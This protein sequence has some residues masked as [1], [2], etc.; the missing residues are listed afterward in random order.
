MVRLGASVTDSISGFTGIAVSRT[1]YLYG[2]VRVG[3][4][5]G[6]LKDGKPGETQYFDEQRLSTASKAKSGG[7]GAVPPPREQPA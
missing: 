3:V 4:E 7:P 1:E 5:P 6:N 2:C